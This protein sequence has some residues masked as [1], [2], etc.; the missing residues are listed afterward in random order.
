M[1]ISSKY[2]QNFKLT[3]EWYLA[4]NNKENMKKFSLNQVT[5]QHYLTDFQKKI[6]CRNCQKKKFNKISKL[7]INQLVVFFRKKN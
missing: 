5:I 6:I 1:E 7:A 2:K 4:N 3:A